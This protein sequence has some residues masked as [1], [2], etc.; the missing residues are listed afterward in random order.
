M[1]PFQSTIP[2]AHAQDII[3]AAAS[4]LDR[5]ERVPLREARG[6]CWPAI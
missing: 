6:R 5:T 3:A 4:P 2:L 1:R